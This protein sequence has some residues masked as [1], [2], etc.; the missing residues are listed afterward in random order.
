MYVASEQGP[1]NAAAKQTEGRQFWADFKDEEAR[2]VASLQAATIAQA[3][4]APGHTS[5]KRAATECGMASTSGASTSAHAAATVTVGRPA[6]RVTS[7]PSMPFVSRA[8]SGQ[9]PSTRTNTHATAQASGALATHNIV[10]RIMDN[11]VAWH[12]VPA[13][14]PADIPPELVSTVEDQK[15]WM[16]LADMEVEVLSMQQAYPARERRL[17][18]VRHAKDQ[19][20]Q[21]QQ[22]DP[23]LDLAINHIAIGRVDKEDSNGRGWEVMR[24]DSVINRV[25]GRRPSVKTTYLIPADKRVTVTS[26]EW[27]ENWPGGKFVLLGKAPEIVPGERKP[28]KAPFVPHEEPHFPVDCIVWSTEPKMTNGSIELKIPISVQKY[29]LDAVLAIVAGSTALAPIVPMPQL[30]AGEDGDD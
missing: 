1:T 12:T 27:P 2:F 5:K 7:V 22:Y 18:F 6:P 28:R 3:S 20:P 26:T 24:I 13:S 30:G 15:A 19:P 21:E 14:L 4:P 8:Y 9:W 23:M 29:A 17:L 25:V 11:P 16:A 10:Q